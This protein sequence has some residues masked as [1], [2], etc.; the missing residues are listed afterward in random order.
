MNADLV[1]V[2]LLQLQLAVDLG[3]E[4]E[5]LRK[6]AALSNQLFIILP[7]NLQQIRAPSSVPNP[8]NFETNRIRIL[9]SI[10]LLYGSSFG[11]KKNKC[12]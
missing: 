12:L 8:L 3:C 7:K 11:R 2:L 9:G 6:G 10:S 5:H 1:V 4:I